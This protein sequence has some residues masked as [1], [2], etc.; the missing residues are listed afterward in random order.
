M[1]FANVPG[2]RG[3]QQARDNSMRED[4]LDAQS[5]NQSLAGA[6]KLMQLQE[7]VRAR[8]D[9]TQLRDLFRKSG[10]DLTKMR[11]SAFSSGMYKQ[12][13]EL[14]KRL[15]DQQK[16]DLDRMNILS[17]VDD[18]SRKMLADANDA[19]GAAYEHPYTIYKT[20]T[21]KGVPEQ[22]ARQEAQ[23]AWMTTR[24]EAARSPLLANK[25]LPEAFDPDAAL[26]ALSQAK[27]MKDVF[28]RFD[29]Q[30]QRTLTQRG[31]DISM[32]G[33]DLSAETTR[34]GQDVS[35]S[36][37]RRGQDMSAQTQRRGQDMQFDPGLAAGRAEATAM[38]K[39]TGEARATA[40]ITLPQATATAERA[41]KLVD[42]LLKHPGF[43]TSVGA[44]MMPGARLV[45]GTDAADFQARFDEI[46]GGAFMQAFETLKGGGQI[47][48]REGQAAT[49]AITRMSLAQ[50]ETEFRR[51]AKEFQ[52]IARN[53][54]KRAQ[55]KAGVQ[56]QSGATGSFG[57]PSGGIKFL[58]FE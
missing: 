31:Q 12:G 54:L 38:G 46:K 3:F 14:D 20:L 39:E 6:G 32:R 48:E 21:D 13:L 42:D 35:A 49:Q 2:L 18:R 27:R 55:Q 11:D 4:A 45:P 36:T 44:T 16:S 26:G 9:E 40:Q 30:A 52:D 51:A 33:Q 58:G 17:Q 5:F 22:L 28:D 56:T 7:L 19:V 25:P 43:S 37:Q 41:V 50:S 8:N 23:A 57:A 29:K 15:R 24:Q 47:T 34:R 1:D 53:A 10:G